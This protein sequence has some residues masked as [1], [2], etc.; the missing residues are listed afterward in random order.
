VVALVRWDHPDR[1]LL[2]PI[3][4]V[5][6]AERTGLIVPLGA[7]VLDEACRQAGRWRASWIGSQPLTMSVNLSAGQ[8]G[9]IQ[10]VDLVA[11][12]LEATGTPADQ[13]WLEVTETVVMQDIEASIRTLE[14]LK[15]L[16]VSVSVDDFGTGHSSLAYLSR[17]PAAIL[18]VDRAFVSRLGS[19][20]EDGI[21]V[22]A[23]VDLAHALGMDVVAEGVENHA[24]QRAVE[25]L[26]CE[27]AQGYHLARPQAANLFES[28]WAA[29]AP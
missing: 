17:L 2:H 4:F 25:Q 11:D 9:H 6:F 14:S 27:F 23:V 24:Q 20:E 3:D 22:S 28:S 21:I 19:S 29:M 1:G 5:P 8:L 26:G 15:A 10:L 16:G 18:K 12:T 13:L 7:W